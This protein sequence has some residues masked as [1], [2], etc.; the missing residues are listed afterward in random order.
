MNRIKY[1]R[2]QKG[3]TIR[4]LADKSKVAVGYLSDMENSENSNPT[5][6]VMEKVAYA[7]EESVPEVFF[8]NKEVC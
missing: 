2:Q 4:E 7:L 8:P 1:F 5:K 6:E 3:M